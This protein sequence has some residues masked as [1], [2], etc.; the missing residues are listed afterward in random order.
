MTQKKKKQRRIK[1]KFARIKRSKDFRQ[2]FKYFIP[3]FMQ[4]SRTLDP[5]LLVNVLTKV[6]KMA[7]NQT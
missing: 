7:K 2:S 3:T 5:Q 6:I 4:F 1:N